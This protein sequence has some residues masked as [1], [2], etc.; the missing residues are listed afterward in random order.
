MFKKNKFNIYDS[1]NIFEIIEL[2]PTLKKGELKK[3]DI[4]NYLLYYYKRLP[5]RLFHA[6]FQNL[7]ALTDYIR[8]N[9]SE[10]IGIDLGIYNYLAASNNER[11]KVFIDNSDFM[12][13]LF[14]KYNNRIN[15]K[16][17][18][19]ILAYSKLKT[20][21][22]NHINQVI[23]ELIEQTK[24]YKT[25]FVLGEHNYSNLSFP[26]LIFD[27]TYH[28]LKA[29]MGT[30][31]QIVIVDESC[32]SI[33][34]PVCM[35]RDKHNRSKSNHFKCKNCGYFHDNDDIVAASNIAK[36]GLEKIKNK[37]N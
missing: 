22:T 32:T 13:K 36:K 8:N 24:N 30:Q 17:Y 1:V 26:S 14:R 20:G 27:I 33:E 28:A 31:D 23:N 18:D 5:N 25:V 9:K 21:L 12:Y 7:L 37:N 10:I 29:K 34:C 2:I 19:N 15:H 6:K 35:Y 16:Q 3:I 4:P 11:S